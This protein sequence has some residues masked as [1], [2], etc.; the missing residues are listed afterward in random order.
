MPR[1]RRHAVGEIS[2]QPSSAMKMNLTLTPAAGTFQPW[3]RAA[4]R[5]VA[6]SLVALGLGSI[7]AQNAVT[8]LAGSTSLGFGFTNATGTSA[9]FHFTN[10]SAVAVDGS[11]NL[12]VADAL[13]NV[14]RKVT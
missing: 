8:T 11:G 5:A 1:C 12:Y 7:L 2:Q 10:P 6:L 3:A 13:N 9:Q 14:I 4:R